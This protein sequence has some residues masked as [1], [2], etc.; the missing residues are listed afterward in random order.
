[1][2]TAAP[3]RRPRLALAHPRLGRGGSEVVALR[4]LE[5]LSADYA[6][7]LLTTGEVDWPALNALAGTA[8][9]PRSVAVLRPPLPAALRATALG[10]AAREA[11]HQRFCRSV[12]DRFDLLVSAY[13][14]LD[15]G[16]RALHF[17]AD[18][19][20]D[21]TLARRFDPLPC[22]PR[23]ALHRLPGARAAWHALARRLGAPSPR[24]LFAPGDLVVANSRFVADLLAA[25]HGV[26][27]PVL[28]PPVAPAAAPVPWAERHPRFVALGR[29]APEKRLERLVAIVAGV[30]ARGHAVEL[31]LV[32]DPTDSAYG[33]RVARLARRS[34]PWVIL[35][36]PLV[37]EAK[38]AYLAAS[39]YGLHGREGE[40]FGLA[41]A[42]LAAAGA[43]PFVPALGGAAEIVADPELVWRDPADAVARIDRLLRR[44]DAEQAALSDALRARARAFD[45]AAFAAGARALVARFR[46]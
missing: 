25:H 46:G 9:D 20:F 7:T 14:P 10:A 18:L 39:R 4:L 24:G 13:N 22:G 42:E 5:A 2:L 35:T 23:G 19:S 6:L 41:V 34:G 21:P 27:A 33:A 8:V 3:D 30:R 26:T 28:Y 44:P 36:G 32:G 11:L 45:A 17:V 16:R 38:G 43:L 31:H 37:G 29:F 15:F 12:A 1:M 40:P